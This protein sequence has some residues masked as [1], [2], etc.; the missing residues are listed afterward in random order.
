M[1]GLVDAPGAGDACA[2]DLG[3]LPQSRRVDSPN[4]GERP[5]GASI[6]L[7]V[8]HNISLP[9][10]EFG[11]P[12]VEQLFCG[13]L[14]AAAHPYFAQIAGNPV[15]AH[16]FIRRDGE[17]VQFVDLHKRAW[18]AGRSCWQGRDECNDYGI[19]IELEGTDEQPFTDAQ[20]ARLVE[21]TGEI[22]RRF[23]AI[24][25]ERIV[26]HSDVAPGR[27]T[28]PGPAFDWAYYRQLLAATRADPMAG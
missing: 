24:T 3:W 26:G 2:P 23:P 7:L 15:S 8:I 1:K 12:W 25:A 13:R 5:A 21:L 28:D 17:S 20:Y 18:H 11:G 4:F 16:L 19:G 22:M 9:P 6:D 10:G 14:D 27:K